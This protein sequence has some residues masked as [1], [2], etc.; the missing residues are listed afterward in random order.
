MLRAKLRVLLFLLALLVASTFSLPSSFAAGDSETASY[1]NLR[2]NQFMR[3]WLVLSPISVLAKPEDG[4]KPADVTQ[5]EAF[6]RDFLS[7]Q[8]G[9]TGGT[10][11]PGQKI[12]IGG[13][14]YEWRLVKAD[15][16]V[17]SFAPDSTAPAYS[18]AY[19]WA[20]IEASEAGSVILGVGSDDGVK[21]WVNGQVVHENW[22]AR[23]VERDQ[24]LFPVRLNKGANRILLKVQNVD[25]AWGFACRA[26]DGP[27]MNNLFVASA[28]RDA[29]DQVKKL[30]QAGVNVNVRASSGLTALQSARLHG[31]KDVAEYL[32]AHGADAALPVPPVGEVIDGIFGRIVKEDYPGAAVLVAKEGKVIYRKAFGLASVENKTPVTPE[33]RFRIGSIT[34]QFT[35]AAVLRLREQGKI[36]LDD[37]L[38]KFVPDFPRGDE[39]TIHHL[40]THT[41]GIHSYTNKPDFARTVTVP[42]QADE[43]IQSFKNDPYDFNPGQRWLYNNSGFFLLGYIIEKITGESYADH[44][45][46]T[47]FEPLGMKSTGVHNSTDIIEHEA[48][49]YSWTDGRVRKAVNWDMSRAGGAGAL[50]STVD[51]LLLWNEALFGGKLIGEANLQA[52]ET[53][54]ITAEDKEKSKEEGYGYGL[55]ISKLRGLRVVGHGGGLQGFSSYLMAVPEERFTVVVL[56]N[57]AP[58]T[59]E[60]SPNGL[61]TEITELCLGEKMQARVVPAMD[62]SVSSSTYPDYVGKYDYGSAILTVTQQGSQLF[63]QLSGQPRAEIFPKAKDLF[64]WK[65]VEAEVTFV[66]DDKGRVTK[67]VHRQNGQTINAPRFDQPEAVKADGATLEALVGKYDYGSGAIM[68][69]TR[70]GD[71]LFAQLTGQPKFEIF[72]KSESEFFWKVVNAQV[73]FVKDTNG[74]VT[75]AIHRQGG[76]VIQAPRVE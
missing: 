5:R 42:I 30:L 71:R 15:S 33:T 20:E 70:E 34:K 32:L 18:I 45:R 38:S 1:P 22:V 36:S 58:A 11:T 4:G 19:A 23:G 47:F 52:A 37:K 49:G 74:K 68:T 46:K 28:G 61:A 59:P 7:Q 24:D 60:M 9:E 41:S 55:M 67:A 43:L 44:L 25:G 31:R 6:D 10:P 64:F 66:R 63:A 73:R 14:D 51:D 27:A 29:L 2:P 75:K 56:C 54:V 16:D 62:S 21:V 53:P 8:G 40:L 3:T 76:A 57:S 17:V 50:Y 48:Y 13:K 69:V 26:L 65:V 39:V 12:A 35:A 72:A